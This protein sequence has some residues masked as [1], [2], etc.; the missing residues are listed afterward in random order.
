MMN[1]IGSHINRSSELNGRECLLKVSEKEI[2][3]SLL[4]EKRI[5][6][7]KLTDYF[8]G[9]P[10]E[11]FLETFSYLTIADHAKYLRIN[12]NWKLSIEESLNI[13]SPRV[14]FGKK[15][16]EEYFGDIGE[17][18]SL[19]KEGLKMLGKPCPFCPGEIIEKT[20]KWVLVPDAVDENLLT[21]DKLGALIE[22]PKKGHAANY[23]YMMNEYG[24]WD[25]TVFQRRFNKS[26]RSHWALMP[27]KI[28]RGS[29]SMSFKEQQ[30]WVNQIAKQTGINYEIPLV[31]D[32]VAAIFTEHVVS[33]NRLFEGCMEEL[34][35]NWIVCQ[36]PDQLGYVVSIGSFE[37]RIGLNVEV[38]RV[39][40]TRLK[41]KHRGVAPVV[42]FF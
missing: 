13:V 35:D 33:G 9:L 42:R 31:R 26:A 16:W 25:D 29:R 14:I 18:P 36:D 12:R 7:K 28:A 11:L 5:V 15:Q 40:S 27:R 41:S 21:L 8:D 4:K 3:K 6:K 32:A 20:H 24:A 34:P 10:Q 2:R 23:G 17:V 38:Y 19:P 39:N 30:E 37:E 22:R 1:S